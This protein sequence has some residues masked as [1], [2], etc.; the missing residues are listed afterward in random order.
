MQGQGDEQK[1]T[2]EQTPVV[3]E[4]VEEKKQADKNQTRQLK[5]K[6][7]VVRRCMK[8][9]TSYKKEE[10]LLK[11]KYEKA[12]D[13]G[14]SDAHD[15]NKMMEHVQETSDTLV[16]CKPRIENAIDE[17]E[18]VMATYEEKPGEM[19]D[20]LKTTEEWQQAEAI[21]AEGKAFVE[22]IEI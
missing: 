1:P 21:I 9:F 12:R 17:L 3:E 15:L 10:G 7:G 8:D 4:K 19:F 22:A 14:N 13:E 6:A 18:N 11:E 16:T 20:I 2:E 5:I